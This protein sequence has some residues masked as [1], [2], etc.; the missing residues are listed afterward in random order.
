MIDG[1]TTSYSRGVED[2]DCVIRIFFINNNEVYNCIQYRENIHNGN[3]I[4]YFRTD[5]LNSEEQVREMEE[6]LK[7]I[8]G[9][10]IRIYPRYKDSRSLLIIY[11]DS[12]EKVFE[13]H[14]SLWF[15][16]HRNDDVTEYSN[17]TQLC[18]L[19]INKADVLTV[20][21][22]RPWTGKKTMW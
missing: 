8:E 12:K 17:A 1:R 16:I 18:K 13:Y 22:D 19:E 9:K 3:S 2:H 21:G 15:G 20:I 14:D 7:T 6:L 10:N 5:H 4:T 11:S